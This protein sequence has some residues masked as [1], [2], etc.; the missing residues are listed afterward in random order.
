MDMVDGALSRDSRHATF[1]SVHTTTGSVTSVTTQAAHP[2][3]GRCEVWNAQ[4]H[5]SRLPHFRLRE[6]STRYT[7]YALPRLSHPA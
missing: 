6:L 3:Q 7:K 5:T 2:I 4:I 1:A